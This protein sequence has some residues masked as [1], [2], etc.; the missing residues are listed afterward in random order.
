MD[1]GEQTSELVFTV[2]GIY[3]IAVMCML[4]DTRCYMKDLMVTGQL[5]FQNVWGSP[6]KQLKVQRAHK[7][8]KSAIMVLVYNYACPMKGLYMSESHIYR[9]VNS[10][11]KIQ[12]LSLISLDGIPLCLVL[13]LD[14]S[15]YICCTF[16]D[17]QKLLLIESDVI[18]SGG[19]VTVYT[20][21]AGEVQLLQLK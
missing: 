19:F 13:K 7:P 12:E 2:S 5:L 21:L 18:R 16:T 8:K 3:T 15:M 4:T 6:C 1:D 11:M 9:C 14:G 17:P 10:T 20:E